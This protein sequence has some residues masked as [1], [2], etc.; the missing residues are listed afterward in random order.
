MNFPKKIWMII[1]L[2]L[3]ISIIY[4]LFKKIGITSILHTLESMNQPWLYISLAFAL[5][6]CVYLLGAMGLYALITP[7]KRI[8]LFRLFKYNSS[9]WAAGFLIPTADIISLSYLL[10]KEGIDWGP[11][12]VINFLDKAI[13]L[14]V[15]SALS[16]LA[17]IKFLSPPEATNLVVLLM[18][19]FIA[20]VLIVSPIGR[21]LI[22]RFILRKYSN[23]F[24]GFWT[25]LKWYLLKKKALILLNIL[26]TILK[27]IVTAAIAYFIF[28]SMN[29]EVPIYDITLI[30]A[31]LVIIKLLPS[32]LKFLGLREAAGFSLAVFFYT[33][34]GL[35]TA[36]IIG[37]YILVFALNYVYAFI[38]IALADYKSIIK[39]QS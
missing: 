33:K 36:E 20:L 29:L 34:I 28:L 37:A 16:V 9:S 32:P 14:L 30:S 25:V 13:T 11:G 22:K 21:K 23:K 18:L 6:I 17:F 15:I 1:K 35:P 26:L 5:L 31:T 4:L 7:I 3:G 38:T 24:R 39:M 2:A 19:I 10:K 8:S 12:L 27:F